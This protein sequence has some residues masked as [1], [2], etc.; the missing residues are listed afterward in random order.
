LILFYCSC[1]FKGQSSGI[2]YS[3]AIQIFASFITCHALRIAHINGGGE[4]QQ[5]CVACWHKWPLFHFYRLFILRVCLT[6]DWEAQEA[7]MFVAFIAALM[8]LII[9]DEMLYKLSCKLY[10]YFA[11]STT[12]TPMLSQVIVLY[13]FRKSRFMVV[14]HK[15]KK[16]VPCDECTWV[17]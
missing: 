14:S 3:E 12:L 4:W 15:A 5:R 11:F 10:L 13:K 1:L 16:E 2:V 8:F 9:I 17:F 6:K 7:Q